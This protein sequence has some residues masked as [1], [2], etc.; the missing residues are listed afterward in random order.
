MSDPTY[1]HQSPPLPVHG[2]LVAA[3][4]ASTM[5][6]LLCRRFKH[7]WAPSVTTSLR[8]FGPRDRARVAPDWWWARRVSPKFLVQEYER[9]QVARFVR[10]SVIEEFNPGDSISMVYRQSLKDKLAPDTLIEGIVISKRNR[11]LGSSFTIFNKFGEVGVERS[12]P[13]YS[14]FIKS[15]VVLQSRKVRRAKLYYLKDILNRDT[16]I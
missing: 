5:F 14:P 7:R 8:A 13:M 11:G 3:I 10:N 9:E 16:R 2:S 12:F 15:I 6:A 1:C 4:L